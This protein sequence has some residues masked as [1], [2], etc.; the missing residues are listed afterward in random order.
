MD[1]INPIVFN[2]AMVTSATVAESDHPA[3]TAGD[4]VVG[5]RVI[6]A[7]THRRYECA[8]AHTT[9]A[10]STSATVTI[11][12]AAPAAVTWNAHGLANGAEVVFQTTGSLPMGLSPGVKYYVS[13]ATTNSF[14]LVASRAVGAATITTTGTQAGVHTASATGTSPA[15][16]SALWIDLGA[17]NK[18]AAFDEKWGTQTTATSTLTFDIT[19]GV[20]VD[21]LALLN[22]LGSSVT[23]TCKVGGTTIYTKTATLQTDVGVYDWKTYFV[24]PI[25]A[26]K[27]LVFTDL[28]PYA[29]QVITITITG[30]GTVAIGNV[31][32][33]SVVAL[34]AMEYGAKFGI[35]SYSVKTTDA[36]GNISLSSRPYSKGFEGRL[37]VPKTFVDQLAGILSSLRDT[38][39]IWIGAGNKYSSLIVWGFL[40]DFKFDLAYDQFS[41]CSLSIEGLV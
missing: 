30:S 1:V 24:A 21:S 2:A 17:T 6:L 18:F 29:N 26:A 31:T 3:W 39:A 15:A 32:L 25:V 22:L 27:D 34:G 38:P 12:I 16:N 9:V 8:A 19:P 7:S 37:I 20:A 11:S 13:G 23:V 33:G 28:L 5:N 36:Y 41:F 40:D 10:A 35:K 4:Y 14:N